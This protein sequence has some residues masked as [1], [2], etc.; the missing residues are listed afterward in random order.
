MEFK[1]REDTR[2][3]KLF[4]QDEARFGRIDNIGSRW[5][6]PGGRAK[7]GKQIIRQYTYLYGAFC[8]ETGENCTLILPCAN[9]DC[10][11]IFLEEF[12]SQFPGYRIVMCMDRASWHGNGI[13]RN[14]VPLFLPAHSPELN[15][16]ENVWHYIRESGGFKNRTFNSMD[17]VED[18]LCNA[19]T[20]LLADRETVKSI[21]AYPWIKKIFKVI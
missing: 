17:E 9:S 11:D 8:P 6:P 15:P 21:T 16:A 2:P 10:M 18:C 5:V 13:T 19:V 3:V 7:V 14:I 20:N 12:S 1:N 4:F